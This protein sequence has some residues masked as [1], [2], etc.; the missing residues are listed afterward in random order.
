[1]LLR[2]T[3]TG[4]RHA[5]RGARRV[6]CL[7]GAIAVAALTVAGLPG[8]A[9]TWDHA[10]GD[11]TNSGFADVATLPALRPLATVPGI[12]SYAPGAGPVIGPDGTV[13]LG[14]EQGELRALHPDG[15]L[16]WKR[17]LGPPAGQAI[18]ASPV[19]DT[20][21][22]IY[23]VGVRTYT[24]NRVIPAVK[25]SES[26][27]HRFTSG[28]GYLW[29]KLF[30]SHYASVPASAGNGVTTAPPNI[31]RSG[32]DAAILVPAVYRGLATKDVRLLAFSPAGVLLADR[33]VNAVGSQVFG[34]G[35][36][37]LPFGFCPRIAQPLGI[38]LPGVAI[39]TFRGGGTPWII[40]TDQA[41]TFVGW[42]FSVAGGFTERFRSSRR[43]NW[44]TSAPMILPDGHS[45]FGTSELGFDDCGE[46]GEVRGVVTFGGPNGAALSDVADAGGDVGAARTA[47]GRIV[48]VDGALEILRGSPTPQYISIS[49]A[50]IAP[51]AVSRT[52]IYVST[53]S[54]LLSYDVNTLAKV[55][56]VD[57]AGGGLSSPAIGPSGRVYALASNTLFI[58]SGPLCPPVGCIVVTGGGVFSVR[59]DLEALLRRSSPPPTSRAPQRSH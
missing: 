55:G 18:L 59:G 49:G 3:H 9:A 48:F 36:L 7:L 6:R 8:Q 1:M 34:D 43:G 19:V 47:D 13:Y 50:A 16:A 25:R 40:A 29:D 53:A 52:H 21:G 45:V 57:W 24:D 31:W 22:S 58:W 30:P 54:A 12:G 32:T 37:S 56:E 15:S 26:R 14:N 27:L 20:D 10:H 38:P 44:M 42:T 23:V 33:L 35:G 5:S 11:A 39:F 17:T 51:A 2:S 28:G 46:F 4:W 41:G